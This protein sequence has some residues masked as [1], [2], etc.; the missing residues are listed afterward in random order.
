MEEEK[1][2]SQGENFLE[3]PFWPAGCLN[4]L[5][6]YCRENCKFLDPKIL[7]AIMKNPN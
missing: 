1:D 3:N 7:I 6:N 5:T 4:R 2:N